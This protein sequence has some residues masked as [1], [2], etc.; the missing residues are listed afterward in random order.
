NYL[1][2]E[3]SY[4]ASY[5]GI[6]WSGRWN[7]GGK[8][9][10][11]PATGADYIYRLTENGNNFEI[12]ATF[13]HPYFIQ[14]MASR[15]DVENMGNGVFV[16]DKVSNPWVFYS[17]GPPSSYFEGLNDMANYLPTDLDINGWLT[18][19]ADLSDVEKL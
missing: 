15:D 19:A 11:D 17:S 3:K 14:R 4:P 13:E 12:E 9:F 16:F 5:D 10:A 7:Y 8:R 2:S 6:D 1:R 18:L